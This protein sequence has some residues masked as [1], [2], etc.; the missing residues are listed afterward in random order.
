MTALPPRIEDL[1]DM[2][3][4]AD[5]A[6]VLR[7]SKSYVQAEC[8]A[9]KIACRKIA[10]R[11]LIRP[12]AVLAYFEEQAVPCQ[13]ETEAPGSTGEQTGKSGKSDGSS[14]VENARNRRALK[15]AAKLKRRSPTSSSAQ[16]PSAQ[17]IP[18]NAR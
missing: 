12:A 6:A 11:F 15:I 18:L 3:T 13:S 4:V 8:K 10:G 1:P 14:E 7:C 2:A 9:G 5:V 17:V 16:R